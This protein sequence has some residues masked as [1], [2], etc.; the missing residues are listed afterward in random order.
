MSTEK[1]DRDNLL[2]RPGEEIIDLHHRGLKLLQNPRFF[3]YSGDAFKL[4]EYAA[5]AQPAAKTVCE[6]GSGNGG[7]LLSLW[8]MLPT[9][10]YTG[11]EI[12]P[13]NVDLARRSLLL[14]EELPGLAG[15]LRFVQGDWRNISEILPAENYDLV[16]SNPPFWPEKSG[17]LSPVW[18]RRVAR[19]EMFGGLRDVVAAAE[20]LL[21]VEGKFCLLLPLERRYEAEYALLNAGLR[22]IDTEVWRQRILL[23]GQKVKSRNLG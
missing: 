9:A 1:T 15:H 3:G 23:T 10:D 4:A 12:L 21:E 2:V 22:V 17:R 7:L 8:G 18:E 16:V 13:A 5:A 19:S 14:N 20:Y 6:L 11:L